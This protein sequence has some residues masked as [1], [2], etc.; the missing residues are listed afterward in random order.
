MLLMLARVLF[1]L[2]HLWGIE[3]LLH[4]PLQFLLGKNCSMGHIGYVW[5]YWSGDEGGEILEGDE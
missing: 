4:V 5:D 2:A 1:A 3:V